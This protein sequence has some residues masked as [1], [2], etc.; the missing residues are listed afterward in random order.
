MHDLT[1][2]GAWLAI[3]IARENSP[4]IALK[5]IPLSETIQPSL[6]WFA[7]KMS[8]F[9]VSKGPMA[10]SVFLDSRVFW[11]YIETL[12]RRHHS[13]SKFFSYWIKDR[14]LVQLLSRRP[15]FPN[16]NGVCW[17][18]MLRILPVL[19][20]FLAAVYFI[21]FLCLLSFLQFSLNTSND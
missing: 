3:V 2:P 8:A 15:Y 18:A 5:T 11:K 21:L 6:T 19:F 7:A 13:Q 16:W 4:Q 9:S 1:L 17:N 12:H 14:L 20:L 10:G